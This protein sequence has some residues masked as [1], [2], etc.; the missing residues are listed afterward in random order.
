VRNARAWREA[1]ATHL[2]V[3]TMGSG[4]PGLDAHLDALAK[5]G[6]ALQL[7][8]SAERGSHRR[9]PHDRREASVEVALPVGGHGTSRSRHRLVGGMTVGRG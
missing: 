3:D 2:S 1:G 9:P 7:A 8:G 6:E 5:A 4:L